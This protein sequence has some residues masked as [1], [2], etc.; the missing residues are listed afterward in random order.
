MT[1]LPL[2]VFDVNETLLD[3]ETME[4]TF[5]R[6]FGDKSAM[7]LWFSNLILY[8]AAL[9]VAGCYVPFTDIG[10]AVMKMLAD[11]RGIKIDDKDSKELMEKFSTMP[12][13]R[14]VPAAL[15]RLRD[16]GF[17]LFTLT[18]NL[19]E[20]Q[21]RQLTHGGIVD[22]F[23]RRFSADG[24]KHHKPSRQ[25]Y[26]YVE[27]ELGAGPSRFCLIACHTWDTLGAVA[28]GW[29]GALIKRTGND[30]LGVGPQPHFVGRDLDDIA[31]Q[32]IARY[33]EGEQAGTQA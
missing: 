10:A 31:D 2:I 14:E 22:L 20:V 19:L 12:P 26:G 15:R 4:P 25:A 24:V 11:T 1:A 6:I 8:S 9:T 30:V 27:K 21:T 7:R 33:K 28:A 23:E 29:Q 16:A 3:L 5:Q 17:R 32:M 18:D 13:H